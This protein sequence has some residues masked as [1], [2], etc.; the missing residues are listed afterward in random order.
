M[1]F[2]SKTT[3]LNTGIEQ[4]IYDKYHD[5]IIYGKLNFDIPLPPPY[6]R[7]LWDYKKAN[8]GTI[9]RAISAFNWDMAFYNKDT[10]DKIKILNDETLLDIFSNFI[11][12]KISEFD[13]KKPVWM[14]KKI[15]L[16]LK[17]RSKLKNKKIKQ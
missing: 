13:Y 3:Y 11:P 1:I 16:L 14:N 9:Q 12:N 17:K 5:N 7:K 8:T 15:T 10:N 2:A 6:Y 4:S